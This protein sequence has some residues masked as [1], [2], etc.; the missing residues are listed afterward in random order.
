MGVNVEPLPL[1]PMHVH[2]GLDLV[3][4]TVRSMSANSATSVKTVPVVC[5]SV[6]QT[7]HASVNLGLYESSVFWFMV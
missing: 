3:E 5:V 1:E 6:Q 2:V 4:V 7:W